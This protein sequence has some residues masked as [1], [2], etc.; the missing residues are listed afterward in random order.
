MRSKTQSSRTVF[1]VRYRLRPKKY[2]NKTLL[3][4]VCAEVE[5]TVEHDR[6]LCR[7]HAE[8]KDTEECECVLCGVHAEAEDIVE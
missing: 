2:L 7:V 8:T 4:E 5:D 1:S 6:V 3:Y